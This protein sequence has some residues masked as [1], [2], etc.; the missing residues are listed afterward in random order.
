MT[1]FTQ[2][3]VS[4]PGFSLSHRDSLMMM[5]SCFAENI[6][7][8]LE[9]LHYPV[10]INPFGIVFNPVSIAAQ[11][12]ILNEKKLFT[13]EELFLHQEIWSSYIHH[14]R[15][16]ALSSRQCL[17]NI[18]QSLSLAW[19]YL[20]GKTTMLITFGTAWVYTEKESGKIVANCHKVPGTRFEKRLLPV[21]E[22]VEIWSELIT[23]FQEKYPEMKWVFTVSP[24][25]HWRDGASQNQWSKATLL[26][27][28]QQLTEKF[29]ENTCYFPAYEIMMDELRDYRFYEKDMI[30]PNET[31]VKYI[32][33]KFEEKYISPES[34]KINTEIETLNTAKAH[35]PAF[36]DSEACRLFLLQISR[37]KDTLKEKYPF[38]SFKFGN[39]SDI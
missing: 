30:H 10:N 32:W 12:M 31:A 23:L 9:S 34:R 22:I 39:S 7:K 25:R 36:Q 35:R 17:E 19:R 18:N 1:F 5:G 27:S 37:Q 24:V 6:G 26:L 11:C 2:V 33:K 21:E 13:E 38:I 3:P 28:I 16:S 14:S 15:F 20:N 8:T 29:R 4:S